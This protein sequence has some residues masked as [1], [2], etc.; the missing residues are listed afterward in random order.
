MARESRSLRSS[1]HPSPLGGG[2]LPTRTV[3]GGEERKHHPTSGRRIAIGNFFSCK[4]PNK[5]SRRGPR[6]TQNDSLPHLDFS[7]GPGE[8]LGA[9]TNTLHS[10]RPGGGHPC[11]LSIFCRARRPGADWDLTESPTPRSVWLLGHR[12][13]QRAGLPCSFSPFSVLHLLDGSAFPS[14]ADNAT[15]ISSLA[16]SFILPSLSQRF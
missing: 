6:G 10:Q 16:H 1:S 11:A 13:Q 9:L 3:L 12:K 5:F 8:V 4:G 7:C 15:E 2:G 14:C